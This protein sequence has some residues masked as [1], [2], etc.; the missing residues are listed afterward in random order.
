MEMRQCND[1]RAGV[2]SPVS[3]SSLPELSRTVPPMYI[4]HEHRE[5]F[6]QARYGD[7]QRSSFRVLGLTAGV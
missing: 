3:C 7:P 1:M 5:P 6:L 2:K 4:S